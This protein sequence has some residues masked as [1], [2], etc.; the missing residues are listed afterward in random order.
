[1]D[2]CGM[3]SGFLFRLKMRVMPISAQSSLPS[4]RTGALTSGL[5]SSQH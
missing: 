2:S 4:N 1:M 5:A 3:D